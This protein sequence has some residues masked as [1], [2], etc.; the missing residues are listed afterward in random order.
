M[1]AGESRVGN[2]KQQ[3]GFD[4]AGGARRVI[5]AVR[6]ERFQLNTQGRKP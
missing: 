1:L 4:R 3:P 2:V 5:S 6:R